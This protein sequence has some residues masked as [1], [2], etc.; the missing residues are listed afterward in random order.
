MGKERGSDDGR[1]PQDAS[2]R[3]W[4]QQ[5]CVA[6]CE[7][8]CFEDVTSK[9]ERSHANQDANAKEI[10]KQTIDIPEQACVFKEFEAGITV[11]QVRQIDQQIREK[12]PAD[13]T[14]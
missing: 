2:T 4:M 7:R 14:M 3:L 11:D 8:S 6:R 1:I 10:C 5:G 12:S 9:G 13:Q